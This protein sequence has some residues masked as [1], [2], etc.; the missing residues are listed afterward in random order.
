[1]VLVPI[2][3][4]IHEL[5]ITYFSLYFDYVL[6]V[7]YVSVVVVTGNRVMGGPGGQMFAFYKNTLNH[8]LG[9]SDGSEH[10]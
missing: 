6:C 3:N 10:F 8:F 9:I 2:I 5:F 1:M 4:C 7:V